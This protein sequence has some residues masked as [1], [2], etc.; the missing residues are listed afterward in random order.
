MMHSKE[1]ENGLPTMIWIYSILRT[2][3]TKN[4]FALFSARLPEIDHIDTD[5]FGLDRGNNGCPGPG[6][7]TL[8]INGYPVFLGPRLAAGAPEFLSFSQSDE[9]Q[10]RSQPLLGWKRLRPSEQRSTAV[11]CHLAGGA[12]LAS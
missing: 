2:T 3:S 1:Y 11:R 10:L 6:T 4:R 8:F 5:G 12:M 9:S 7:R